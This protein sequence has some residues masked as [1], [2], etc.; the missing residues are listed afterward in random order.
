MS[1]I[2]SD[3]SEN[4]RSNAQ[5]VKLNRDLERRVGELQT[6]DVIPIG[7]AI[8]KTNAARSGKPRWQSY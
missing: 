5:I 4:K 3:L 8:K 7:I 2:L 6:L 1:G